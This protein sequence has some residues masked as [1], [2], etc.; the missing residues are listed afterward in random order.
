ML[1]TF[2]FD[3]EPRLRL[4]IAHLVRSDALIDPRVQLNQ[5]EDVQVSRARAALRGEPEVL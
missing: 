1:L 2:R 5:P 4:H 3:D